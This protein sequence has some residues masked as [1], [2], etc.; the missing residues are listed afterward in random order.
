MTSF[1]S[2]SRR[3]SSAGDRSWSAK[4]RFSSSSL[5][6]RN[7]AAVSITF[8]CALARSRPY[9]AG[10]TVVMHISSTR[11]Y[12]MILCVREKRLDI[13][14]LIRIVHSHDQS[15]LVAFDIEDQQSPQRLRPPVTDL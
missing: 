3:A 2:S 1:F 12:R 14:L 6:W 4:V 9:S 8:G 11:V 13:Q 5:A 15:V 10:L 7:S